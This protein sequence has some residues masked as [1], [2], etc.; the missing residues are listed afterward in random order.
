MKARARA[1][2]SLTQSA[3]T[4]PMNKILNYNSLIQGQLSSS[5]YVYVF[6]WGG[7]G[8]TDKCTLSFHSE[9]MYYPYFLLKCLHLQ[10]VCILLWETTNS[11]PKQSI[12]WA[13]VQAVTTLW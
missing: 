8:H 2:S 6:S 5:T 11:L 9:K 1:P 13:C 4:F 10:G 12:P 7:A 3:F